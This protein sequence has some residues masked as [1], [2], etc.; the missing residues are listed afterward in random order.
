MRGIQ[1][2]RGF[3]LVRS[4]CVDEADTALDDGETVTE[5]RRARQASEQ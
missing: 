1:G 5:D 4:S 2:R 3:T